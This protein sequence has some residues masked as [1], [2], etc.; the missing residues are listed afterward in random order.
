[1]GLLKRNGVN[2]MGY[3]FMCC[4]WATV[5]ASIFLAD[6]EIKEAGLAVMGAVFFVGSFIIF[7]IQGIKQLNKTN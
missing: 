5:L 1:M 3:F 2:I 4:G 6:S 7:E